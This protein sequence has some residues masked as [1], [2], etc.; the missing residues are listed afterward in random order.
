[1]RRGGG[2]EA[3]GPLASLRWML[4][5][6]LAALFLSAAPGTGVAATNHPFQGTITGEKIGLFE[7][8]KDACGVTTDSAGDIYVAD[9][10]Q[11]RVAVFN[12]KEEFLTMITGISPLDSGGVAAIDGPCDL[13]VDSAGNLYVNDY[14]RDVVR[15]VPA[16]YPPAKGTAYGP[17]ETIDTA[18]P[19]GVAVDPASG[20]VYV[21][22]RT[23]VA[24][25]K[26]PVLPG[27]VPAQ[28][29]GVGNLVDGYGVAVSS[30]P[31]AGEYPSTAGFVYVADAATNSVKVYNPAGDLVNPVDVIEGEATPRAG[32]KSL[33]D[34]DLA[35]D[36]GD[37]HL[38]LADNLHPHFESPEAIVYEFSSKGNYRGQLPNPAAEGEPSFLRD[39]EPSGIAVGAGGRIYITS[40][41]FEN[42]AVFVFGPAPAVPTHALSVTKTGPGTGSVASSPPG[43]RCGSACEGEFE[44]TANVTLFATPDRGS[45]LAGF[46]G[47]DQKLTPNSCTVAMGVD[48]AVTAEFEPAPQETLTVAKAGP[49]AGTVAS[50]PTGIECGGS[51]S[52][53]FDEGSTVT[54]TATAAAGSRLAAWSGCDSQ[55][56]ANSC[57]VTMAAA[58]GVTARFEALPGEEEV[59]VNPGP[60]RAPI[61]TVGLP[62]PTPPAGLRIGRA[63]V[64]GATATLRVTVPRP[65]QL[66]ASGRGLRS[67]AVTTFRAGE[68]TLSLRLTGA[69]RRA[70][71]RAKRHKLAVK[72]TVAFAPFD[73]GA[74]LRAAKAVTFKQ[75]GRKR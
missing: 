51:C 74:T 54:L 61:P 31:G 44:Q 34:T 42:A 28:R 55:P 33:V 50:L 26:A 19:T 52:D 53:D 18:H 68:T 59:V 1:M 2:I 25:Y 66:S 16:V 5:L 56:T 6:V 73:E 71:A 15:F 67:A 65:G 32:F 39:G 63:T 24:L 9:Y 38:Y 70:L 29:I 47:C 27:D 7:Q 37:G 8:F 64:K 75:G 13:A 46:S 45:R 11:N 21:D 23:S 69:G 43:L 10:Y 20:D 49:G 58:R 17:K 40:G 60:G 41:N 22:E 72:V 3:A 62:A 4:C 35:I 36:P 12:S 48:H 57:K 30:F 14:H